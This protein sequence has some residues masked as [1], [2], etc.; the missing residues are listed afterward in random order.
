LAVVAAKP[1]WVYHIGRL[2]ELAL[3]SNE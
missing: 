1:V 2:T 3:A